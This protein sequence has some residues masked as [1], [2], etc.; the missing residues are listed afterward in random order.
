MSLNVK[1]P[2]AHKL[3]QAVAKETGETLTEAV[4][5][6]LRERLA[7]LRK[8]RKQQKLVEEIL[9]ISDRFVKQMKGPPIDHDT[10]LYDENGL[11]K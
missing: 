1:S 4:T 5:V 9:A 2:E 11:P 3:A 6:A 7:R 10:F 8:A